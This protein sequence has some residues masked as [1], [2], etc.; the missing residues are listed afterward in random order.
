[1]RNWN[2]IVL[3]K[4]II[5]TYNLGLVLFK[6][7]KEGETKVIG[8]NNKYLRDTRSGVKVESYSIKK[9][10]V[11][12]A[13][14]V[15]GASIFFGAT[16]VAN[17]GKV[18]EKNTEAVTQPTGEPTNSEVTHPTTP[19]Q[20]AV[21]QPA[22]T[23]SDKPAAEQPAE[24][25]SDKPAA[26]QPAGT[27]S[28][29]P[30]AEQP[31]G[32]NSDKPAKEQPTEP[33]KPLDEEIEEKERKEEEERRQH[34]GELFEKD[35][36]SLE[37]NANTEDAD[38]NRVYKEP[39]EGTTAK[40][41]YKV[42]D[43]L[44]DDFQ[45]NELNYLKKMDIIGDKIG[46]KSGE[47]RELGLTLEKINKLGLTPEKLEQL[48]VEPSLIK[49][50]N[51]TPERIKEIAIKPELIK[52]Y[53]LNEKENLALSLIF[54]KVEKESFTSEKLKELGLKDELANRLNLTPERIKE[55]LANPELIKELKLT[56]EENKELNAVFEKFDKETLNPEIL[57]KNGN[58]RGAYSKIKL[59]S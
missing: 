27:N 51:L 44:P 24:T 59:N 30:A 52:E 54:E 6:E 34:K 14:V 29:K 50:L 39:K 18:V 5:N 1:M 48:G 12:A 45:N 26:E 46:L 58:E 23:N 49:K 53:I 28:D 15:I 20:P 56:P 11:G 40:G 4:L 2:I 43:S 25:N 42:L 33:G 22:G 9:F 16:G 8:K 37:E 21:E 35:N 31:A 41:L 55:L 57:K 47:I 19:V 3:H 36:P 32:T 10:K 7:C 13:S 38:A 17:A